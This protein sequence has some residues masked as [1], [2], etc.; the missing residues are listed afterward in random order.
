MARF[1]ANESFPLGSVRRLR[2][3]GH[4]VAA[5]A[6]DSPGAGDRLVLARAVSE[7]R[8]LLTFDR[9]YGELIYYRRLPPPPAVIYL[10]LQPDT[11]HEPG[12]MVLD[13]VNLGWP[14]LEGRFTVIDR[15]GVRQRP[16]PE[17]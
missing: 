16:L 5:V 17:G 14:A 3:A 15:R 2:S 8:I 7:G 12:E 1:L 9:D 6:V 11:P 13:I 10:R 4:D